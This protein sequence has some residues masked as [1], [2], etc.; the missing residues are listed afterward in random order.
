[1]AYINGKKVFFTM[2]T[3]GAVKSVD[4]I[5]P[6]ASGNVTLPYADS[7]GNGGKLRLKHTYG[8]GSGRYGSNSPEYGDTAFIVK[9]TEGDIDA[10][11]NA[12]RPIVSAN[13]DYAVKAALTGAKITW[14]EAE[15]K[16]VRIL[17]G[18]EKE[19]ANET[20]LNNASFDEN[21]YVT[22][23]QITAGE[24]YIVSVYLDSEGN[25]ILDN[26]EITAQEDCMPPDSEVSILLRC[27]DVTSVTYGSVDF[28]IKQVEENKLRVGFVDWNEEGM[29][30]QIFGAGKITLI[31]VNE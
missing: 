12:Y 23:A 3:I 18:L 22:G 1:M 20:I 26:V 21:G 17:L 24:K 27:L 16:A 19:S 5:T 14:T 8:I 11:K 28:Y 13:V 10:K 29:P 25:Q 6:D 9:A 30:N 15:K 4:G 2:S 31:K 7:K